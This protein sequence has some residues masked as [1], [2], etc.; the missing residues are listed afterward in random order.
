[1]CFIKSVLSYT[2]NKKL[3]TISA[4]LFLIIFMFLQ[5]KNSPKSFHYQIFVEPKGD[6]LKER[7][8]WK[9]KFLVSL[10]KEHQIEQL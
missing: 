5:Q 4:L 6:H 8:A 7:D 1:M 2:V 3:I 10:K 9:Q